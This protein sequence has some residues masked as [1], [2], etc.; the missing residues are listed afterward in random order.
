MVICYLLD[1]IAETSIEGGHSVLKVAHQGE[2]EHSLDEVAQAVRVLPDLEGDRVRLGVAVDGAV[3]VEPEPPT[4]SVLLKP[5][6]IPEEQLV[7]RRHAEDGAARFR[8]ALPHLADDP[9]HVRELEK[10]E[11]VLG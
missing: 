2:K 11:H 3:L 9:V 8:L 10:I 4:L 1:V 5:N 6:L 7:A